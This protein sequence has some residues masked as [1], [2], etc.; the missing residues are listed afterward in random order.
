[1]HIPILNAP[2]RLEES[3]S[4]LEEFWS[5]YNEFRDWLRD[6]S[7]AMEVEPD[8]GATL[9]DQLNTVKELLRN[10]EEKKPTIEHLK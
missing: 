1:M 5:N 7:E 4:S 6:S 3:I 10:L 8:P 2:L 9:L